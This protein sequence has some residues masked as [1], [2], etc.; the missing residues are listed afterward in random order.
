MKIFAVH[1]EMPYDDVA[2]QTAWDDLAH[3]LEKHPNVRRDGEEKAYS[4]IVYAAEQD[5]GPFLVDLPLNSYA[6]KEAV[7]SKVELLIDVDDPHSKLTELLAK[8][9]VQIN[10]VSLLHDSYLKDYGACAPGWNHKTQSPISGGNL[11]GINELLLKEDCCTDSL[12]EA[13]DEGWRLLAVC[14]QE[15]R[16]PDYVLGRYNAEHQ[17]GQPARR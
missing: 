3:L 12:Q 17:M 8:L 6:S 5:L 14:P 13:L 2:R 16:R 10:N 15:S 7:A 9:E 11:Q 1:L 4:C